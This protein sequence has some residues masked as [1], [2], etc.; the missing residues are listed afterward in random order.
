MVVGG[1]HLLRAK[2]EHVEN[3]IEKLEEFGVERIGVSHCTGMP[4]AMALA[5]RFE[6]RF[7]FNHAGQVIEI[8]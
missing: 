1:T 4:A 7:I 6:N 8:N 2:K 3:T 5:R